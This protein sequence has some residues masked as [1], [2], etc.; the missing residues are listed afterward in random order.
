MASCEFTEDCQASC[1]WITSLARRANV[2]PLF[3]AV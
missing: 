1:A 2:L 3:S